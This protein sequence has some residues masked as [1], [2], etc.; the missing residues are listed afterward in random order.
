MTLA[1]LP[2]ELILGILYHLPLP[3]L[4]TLSHV[5]SRLRTLTPLVQH[6]VRRTLLCRIYKSTSKSIRVSLPERQSYV[7]AIESEHSVIIPDPYRTLLLEWPNSHP[8]A[9]FYWPHALRFHATG[10]CSCPRYNHESEQ[11]FCK[12]FEVNRVDFF[13]D[14]FLLGMIHRHEPFDFHEQADDSRWELFSNPPRL[15]TPLQNE[16]T[17]RFLRSLPEDKWINNSRHWRQ[18]HI[19]ALRMSRYTYEEDGWNTD[20]EFYMVLEGQA[21]GQIHGW[22][23]GGWYGG[24]E[25][26]SLF[27]WTF[28]SD[29]SPII[30]GYGAG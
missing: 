12:R 4:I 7:V 17:L 2:I 3:D 5:D 11:C 27:D 6:P 23:V 8:P 16:Q 30:V 26:E 13:V 28:N 14:E 18:Y 21:K 1:S 19:N 20:G 29:A 15:H 24:Y 25:A 10:F 22:H 9:G